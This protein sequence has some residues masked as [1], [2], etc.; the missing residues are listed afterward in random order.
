MLMIQILQQVNFYWYRQKIL[1][2]KIVKFLMRTFTCRSTFLYDLNTAVVA[3]GRRGKDDRKQNTLA[4]L[5]MDY[6]YLL[7]G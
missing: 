5:V 6:I 4:P 7:Y 1:A 3:G 2:G